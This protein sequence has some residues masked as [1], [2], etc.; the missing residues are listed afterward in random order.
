MTGEAEARA[1]KER[2]KEAAFVGW[3]V[4]ATFAEV[5]EYGKW[6]ERLNL[7]DPLRVGSPEAKREA[8]QGQANAQRV[9]EAFKKPASP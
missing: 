6:L 8:Q 5:P 9:R 1:T 7:S 3:Q 2:L 4:A